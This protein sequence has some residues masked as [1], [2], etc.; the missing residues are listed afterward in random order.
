MVQ[1]SRK[2]YE[3]HLDDLYYDMKEDEVIEKFIY[4]TNP[5]RG[6]HISKGTLRKYYRRG[7]IGKLL[8]RLD[9]VAFNV[10]YSEWR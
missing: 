5:S 1:K 7:D 6:T 10:G 8:H 4:L 2:E 9:P 3:E